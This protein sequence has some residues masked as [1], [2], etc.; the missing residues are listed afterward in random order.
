MTR[1]LVLAAA[2]VA[3]PRLAVAQPQP[4]AE[5]AD[6]AATVRYADLDLSTRADAETLLTRIRAAAAQVC[7]LDPGAADN[8]S[9]SLFE[10]QGCYRLAV[11][12]AVDRLRAPLVREALGETAPGTSLLARR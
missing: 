12:Q 4:A 2:V 8:S 7:G 1:F 10:A 3:A 5:L 9:K 6:P 11:R